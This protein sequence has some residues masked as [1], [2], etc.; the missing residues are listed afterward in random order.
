M[1]L[2]PRAS[3]TANHARSLSIA[4]GLALAKIEEL[5]GLPHAH[6]DLNNGMHDD[7][8]NPI[9]DN[10]DRRWEVVLDDPLP[11]MRKVEVRVRLNHTT[12]ADSVASLVTYF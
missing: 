6:V 8:D 10:Y 3:Q 4:N 11:G 1:Q 12:S 9:D 7:P 2:A 5:R